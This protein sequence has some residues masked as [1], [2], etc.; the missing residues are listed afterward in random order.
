M[1]GRVGEDGKIFD[2]KIGVVVV[3]WVLDEIKTVPLTS[4]LENSRLAGKVPADR[5]VEDDCLWPEELAGIARR[6]R[7]ES[8]RSRP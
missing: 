2:L 4:L 1:C 7:V 5:D 8:G 6:L 3:C